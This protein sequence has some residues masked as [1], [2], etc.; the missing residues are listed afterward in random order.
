MKQP[1]LLHTTNCISQGT[2][3]DRERFIPR[4]WLMQLWEQ[5]EQI[6]N[7]G[8]KAGNYSPQEVSVSLLRTFI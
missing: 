6:R 1:V 4:T 3:K 7:P 5:A 8:Q 2:T